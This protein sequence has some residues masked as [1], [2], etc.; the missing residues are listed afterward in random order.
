MSGFG[1]GIFGMIKYDS[2]TQREVT[3]AGSRLRGIITF[4]SRM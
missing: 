2:V 1:N 3:K 4:S